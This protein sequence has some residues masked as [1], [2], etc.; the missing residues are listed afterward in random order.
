MCPCICC[1]SQQFDVPQ[2]LEGLPE[3]KPEDQQYF[4]KLLKVGGYCWYCQ[5]GTAGW[6]FWLVSRPD[7]ATTATPAA[8]S[9]QPLAG[10]T[11]P[12]RRGRPPCSASQRF[13]HAPPLACLLP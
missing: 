10:A 4:G 7:T 2:Q 5:D 9:L 1:R 8:G 13:S 12:G 6:C 11:G 3:M